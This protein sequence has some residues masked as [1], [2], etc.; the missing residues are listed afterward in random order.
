MKPPCVTVVKYLL[1]A[2]RVLVM[3]ELMEKH[4]MR[5]I[6]ASAKMDLTPAAI[7]QYIK[8]KRGGIFIDKIEQ[9]E[10]SMEMVSELSEI[11]ARND[12][13]LENVIERL[14]GICFT[15]R[16]EGAV[17]KLHRRDLPGLEKCNIEMCRASSR[18]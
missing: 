3:K 17:C 2:I 9:S 11:L 7:S 8:G 10:E 13:P 12:A 14:C 1:P 6:D 18:D 4:S 5:K 16:S 15:I